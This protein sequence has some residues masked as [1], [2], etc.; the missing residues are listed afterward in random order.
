MCRSLTSPSLSAAPVSYLCLAKVRM[1]IGTE[2]GGSGEEVARIF[3]AP[4]RSLVLEA[5]G[6][7]LGGFLLQSS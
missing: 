7:A 4:S 2:E 1:Y 6:P 5:K 3:L